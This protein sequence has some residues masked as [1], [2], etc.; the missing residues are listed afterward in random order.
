MLRCDSL[1]GVLTALPWLLPFELAR[2]LYLLL[3]APHV[4]GAY[5]DVARELGPAMRARRS[6]HERATHAAPASIGSVS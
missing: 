2:M 6:I 4:L 1:G 5:A 3:T